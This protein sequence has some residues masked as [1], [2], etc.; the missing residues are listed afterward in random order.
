LRDLLHHLGVERAHVLGMSTGGGVAIDFAL[1]YPEMVDA[2]ILVAASIG[3]YATSEA[4]MRLWAEIGAALAE[5]DVPD[6]LAQADL[7]QA[8]IAGARKVVIPEVAHV[9]SMERPEQFNRLVLVS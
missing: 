9:P 2:L 6:M 7:L 8:G 1:A 5:G 4:T 3:G